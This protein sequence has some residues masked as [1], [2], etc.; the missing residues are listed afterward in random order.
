MSKKTKLFSEM[1]MKYK[2]GKSIPISAL[3][4]IKVSTHTKRN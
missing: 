1:F 4:N 2:K 3:Q